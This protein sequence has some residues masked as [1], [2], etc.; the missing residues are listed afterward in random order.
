MGILIQ[1]KPNE[2]YVGFG[3]FLSF[4]FYLMFGWEGTAFEA[5]EDC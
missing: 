5:E 4:I 1:D 2:G 3:S